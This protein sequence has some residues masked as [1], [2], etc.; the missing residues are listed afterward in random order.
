MISME[1]NET[2]GFNH[3]GFI[4]GDWRRLTENS[5]T[6]LLEKCCHDI[7]L[8]NWMLESI[9]VKVA[10]FGGVN[11]FTKKFIIVHRAAA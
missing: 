8:V 6:H 11:F 10:S 4:M 1:F 9:P 3:G 7:D 5:G 2:L